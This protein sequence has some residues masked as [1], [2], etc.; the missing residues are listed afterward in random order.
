[1]LPQIT[2][3]A[4]SS[5]K[6]TVL[7]RIRLS[8]Q[9]K[10][11]KTCPFSL[12]WSTTILLHSMAWAPPVT[13]FKT[14]SVCWVGLWPACLRSCLL[15]MLACKLAARLLVCWRSLLLPCRFACLL[16]Y[17]LTCRS[18]PCVRGRSRYVSST[19][20]HSCYVL[21]RRPRPL[22]T[23]DQPVMGLAVKRG[24]LFKGWICLYSR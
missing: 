8:S 16:A 14:I 13:Q 11:S 4:Y 24:S 18:S 12:L 15:V 19:K 2:C 5:L 20:E 3:P 17:L 9:T 10:A 23:T 7:F 22:Y 21:Y 6:L 1:M